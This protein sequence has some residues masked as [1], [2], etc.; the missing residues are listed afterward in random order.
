MTAM[1]VLGLVLTAAVGLYL[2]I[3]LFRAESF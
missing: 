3:A 2:L 1:D